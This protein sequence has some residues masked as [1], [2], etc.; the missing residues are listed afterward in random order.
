MII[1]NIDTREQV[2]IIAEI[3]NNHEGDLELAKEMI[4]LAAQAGVQAVKFQ[5]IIPEQLISCKQPQRIQQLSR[6]AFSNKQFTELYQV[7]QKAG[8]YFMSTPFSLKSIAFLTPLVPA[9]KIASGDNNFIPLI[10]TVVRSGKPLIISAGMATLETLQTLVKHI[11]AQWKQAEIVQEL[12]L[13]HCM[14]S[15]PTPQKAANLR[16]IET[17]KT[18]NITPGYSDHTLGIEAAVTAVSLGARIIEKHFT[19]DHHHSEFR[20]HQLSANPQELT[21][22]VRRIKQVEVLLGHAQL[23]IS[24]EEESNAVAMRRSIVAARPLSRGH[25]LQFEDFNWVRPG[26]GLRPGQ[27]ELLIDKVLLRSL[28]QGE[29]IT[30]QDVD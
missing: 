22:L 28:E 13:L 23:G 10:D 2:F 4:G 18:L 6:Y 27:E 30:E 5:S 16:A 12:A 29:L 3:G 7:A 1:G 17:L 26:K 9:F 19:I 15:Y 21:E 14:V 8:V 24:P 20:D 11:Q 25:K